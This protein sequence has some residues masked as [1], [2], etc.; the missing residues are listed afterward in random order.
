ME[1]DP[2]SGPHWTRGWLIAALLFVSALR[3]GSDPEIQQVTQVDGALKITPGESLSHDRE[4]FP[5]LRGP[6]ACVALSAD[7]RYLAAGD[8][9]GNLGVIDSVGHRTVWARRTHESPVES[10]AFG[11]DGSI[12]ETSGST[13]FCWDLQSGR[14]VSQ[15]AWNGMS[16]PISFRAAMESSVVV[17]WTRSRGRL[18][19]LG[20]AVYALRWSHDGLE[21][22]LDASVSPDGTWVCI[23]HDNG[24]FQIVSA[25]GA[26]GPSRRPSEDQLPLDVGWH[27][28]TPLLVG[29]EMLLEGH[30]SL[31]TVD[32]SNNSVI[33]RVD[34][35]GAVSAARVQADQVYYST[36]R[37]GVDVVRW[38]PRTGTIEQVGHSTHGMVSGIEVSRDGR[39]LLHF[40]SGGIQVW[41]AR[42]SKAVPIASSTADA[43][44]D[45]SGS[46]DGRLLCALHRDGR[47]SH[48]DLEDGRRTST[49]AAGV[50]PCTRIRF[51]GSDLVCVGDSEI[52]SFAPAASVPSFRG[53]IAADALLTSD[54]R[55]SL[56][57]CPDGR[58]ELLDVKTQS[59]LFQVQSDLGKPVAAST[60]PDS[61]R[62]LVGSSDSN[63]GLA[64]L[65]EKAA[66]LHLLS[67]TSASGVV[68]A[69]I[70]ARD[71]TH[72]LAIRSAAA[73]EEAPLMGRLPPPGS[74]SVEFHDLQSRKSWS[75]PGELRGVLDAAVSADG[76]FVAVADQDGRVWVWRPESPNV[77]V[78]T[79]SM[80]RAV[81]FSANGVCLFVGTASGEIE[82]FEI[83]S[84]SNQ[85]R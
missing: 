81:E 62:L 73:V 39:L 35:G 28:A 17:G 48:W 19:I 22:I 59:R 20:S 77:L 45:L 25:D 38:C 60:S 44:I 82:R 6:M 70:W 75:F 47:L 2:K 52:A 27:G 78:P 71:G 72:A 76:R 43:I 65:R 11:Q 7:G 21:P 30:G 54:C 67:G 49:R 5:F 51:V 10:I 1:E 37:N 18:S 42:I 23:Q 55:T 57:R 66:R 64:D 84:V 15:A 31:V 85:G 79:P 26:G 4:L 32:L 8:P 69:I 46:D 61:T 56:R 24:F 83:D 36:S 9:Q 53:S 74:C 12:L 40:T 3:A 58:L 33:G 50:E 16:P 68:R 80:G 63:L 13:L 34:P 29:Q 41:D 14:Q